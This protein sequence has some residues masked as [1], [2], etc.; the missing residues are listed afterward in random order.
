MFVSKFKY[1]LVTFY[2]QIYFVAL[3]IFFTILPFPAFFQSVTISFQNGINGYNGTVDT[4]IDNTNPNSAY[5][6]ATSILWDSSPSEYTG[7]FRFDNLFVSRGGSIPDGA[8]IISAT[9]TYYVFNSGDDA[10][11]SE[12]LISW[13]N[14]LTWN[15]FDFDNDIGSYIGTAESGTQ[16]TFESIDVTG[17]LTTWSTTPSLNN[18]WIFQ[19]TG[20][21]G[22]DVYSC[23][24]TTLSQR[25]ELTVQ[26]SENFPPNQPTLI[27]PLDNATGVSMPPSLTVNVSDPESDNLDVTY[28]VRAISTSS[29]G[30]F[31]IIGIPDTQYYTN[32]PANNQ[33]F[34]D[35]M[36][37]IVANKDA[38]NI[39][40]ISQF[41]DCVQNGDSYD[42]E[43]QV[44]DAAWSIVEN[45]VTTGLPDGIPYGVNVG[46]HDQTPIGGGSSA[47]TA[48][49][50]EYF[51][52][53][54]FQGRGYYGGYYGSDND[55]H[56]DFFSASGMDFIVVN[57]EYDTTPEQDVLDWADALL[58]SYSNHRAIV[59]SHYLIETDTHVP[60]NTFGTQGQLIYDALKNNP[61]LFLMFC[62]HNHGEGQRTDVNGLF[63]IN[64]LLA[65]YQSYP[66]GGNGFL[67]IMEFRP[68]E[69]K[70][71]IST[72]SPSLDLYETDSNSEF[73]LDYDMGSENFVD[74]GTITNVV[75][76]TSASLDTLTLA[77]E[78]EYEWYV[79]VTDGD[80]SITSQTWS[81]TTGEDQS[82]PVFLNSFTATP[83]VQEINLEWIVES[84]VE[85]AG[86]VIDRSTQSEAGAFVEIASFKYCEELKGRGNAS[87][88]K[89]YFF[90]D[91]KIESD[92][93]YY[94]RL[95]DVSLNGTITYHKVISIHY[96]SSIKEF[97]IQQNN[98]NPFNATTKIN[99]Y[100]P[101]KGNVKITIYN[102]L[103]KKIAELPEKSYE[104]GQNS[105][106]FFAENLSSGTY[107][108]TL[109]WKENI[110]HGKMLLLK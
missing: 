55:N 58:Q 46:N 18:G 53:S 86:F 3:F 81:F 64:T 83:S 102:L 15:Q 37:W 110:L 22:C 28:F 97:N 95:T 65:D 16:N 67:R 9:L 101:Q 26:Y 79:E 75:S 29:E 20:T 72:Y 96:K 105:A 70:I 66:N 74:K 40:Y 36:N 71:Y 103:G 80:N 30:N 31:T 76:G 35:Q 104:A 42:S 89:T 78:T 50:N 27:S 88:S 61:K 8:Y 57:L 100:L 87:D 24:W 11:V 25:P 41:G 63:T 45:P 13:D 107:F 4:Y 14:N 21:D 39:V 33:Y 60:P 73:V 49:F 7:F 5:G 84:E 59:V 19:F 44:A 82:L 85:N 77:Y 94:Y 93:T 52:T 51:G 92:Q 56:Y 17:S 98:P 62:G 6:N 1:F 2:S 99:F 109:K 68:S 10:E 43:W 106:E 12:V 91:T 54:R 69:N 38:L 23:E 90:I 34:Y 108:Y 32:T 47:S 48:K